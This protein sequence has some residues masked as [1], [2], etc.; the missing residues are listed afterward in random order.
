[1]GVQEAVLGLVVEKPRYGYLLARELEPDHA[2]AAVYRAIERLLEAGCL[3]PVEMAGDARQRKWYQ[4]T[5]AGIALYNRQLA[6]RHREQD[7][8]L[9]GLSN[10][11]NIAALLDEYE[12]QLLEQAGESTGEGPIGELF[13]LERR[14]VNDAR[15]EWIVQARE[16]IANGLLDV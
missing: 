12:Q 15:L 2:R 16:M 5:P 11:G 9:A 1:M 7:D 14:L 4:A 10:I 3:E 13:A 6:R 8:L